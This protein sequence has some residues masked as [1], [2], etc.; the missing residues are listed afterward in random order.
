MKQGIGE[1]LV[2]D[3]VGRAQYEDVAGLQ[4]A[5]DGVDGVLI[6]AGIT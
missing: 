2:G 1:I 5:E 6:L 3:E 4:G